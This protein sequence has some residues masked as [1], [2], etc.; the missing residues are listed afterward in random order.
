MSLSVVNGKKG[1]HGLLPVMAALLGNA[2]VTL[3]KFFAFFVSGSSSMFSEAI[4][5]FADTANQSL[6]LIGIRRSVRSSTEDFSYGF[7]LERFLWAL[8]S[9]CGIFFVGAGVTVYHGVM[10]IFHA[11]HVIISPVVY[12]VLI[13][14]LIIESTTFLLAFKDIKKNHPDEKVSEIIANGDPSTMAVLLEDGVAIIGVVIAF[15]S[16]YLSS[17]TGSIY[18]DA[19]GSIL[20]GLMLGLVAIILIAKNREFL[21]HKAI[22]DDVQERIIEIMEADPAIEKVIDFKSAIMDVGQYRIKCEVEFNG[23]A[24]LEDLFDQGELREYFDEINNDFN[25]FTRF[26]VD[27]VDRVPRVVGKRINEIEARI[28]KEIPEVRYMDIEVN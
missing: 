27:Y 22:P 26:A 25:E 15:V 20:I 8:I 11:E 1:I 2:C 12:L 4:H 5:S 10:A 16:M 3:L 13:I 28:Q 6:L 9:A 17:V 14:S 23:S 19:G 18:W 7:G 21:I 24:L